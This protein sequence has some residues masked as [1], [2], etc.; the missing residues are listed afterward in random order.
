MKCLF[1]DSSDKCRRCHRSGLPCIF[2]PRANAASLPELK[3]GATDNEFKRDVQRRLRIIE[4]T[5]GLSEPQVSAY[6]AVDTAGGEECDEEE[7]H[8]E[9]F[10][11][12][13]ALWDATVILQN[14]APSHVPPSVWRKRTVRD[15]W[16]SYVLIQTQYHHCVSLN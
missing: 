14:S 1:E 9:E 3:T 16:L 6:D 11:N 10:N 5:L 2:V 13:S 15:L 4:E 12:L 8:S 7:E